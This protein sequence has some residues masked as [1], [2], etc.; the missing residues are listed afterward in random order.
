MTGKNWRFSVLAFVVSAIASGMTTAAS[1]AD[2]Y[3]LSNFTQFVQAFEAKDKAQLASFV[4]AGS[5]AGQEVGVSASALLEYADQQGNCRDRLLNALYAGCK[6][7]AESGAW[8]CITPP[9]AEDDNVLY[10]GPSIAF[11]SDATGK[12]FKVQFVMCGS[13]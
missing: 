2:D 5:K 6:K 11:L 3:L 7:T 1:Q 4:D 12:S 9:Q 8:G 13:D 10:A